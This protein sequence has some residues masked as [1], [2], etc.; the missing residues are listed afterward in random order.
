MPSGFVPVISEAHRGE[1]VS[2]LDPELL[3]R[4]PALVADGRKLGRKSTGEGTVA[5]DDLGL[6]VKSRPFTRRWTQH[7]VRREFEIGHELLQDGIPSTEPLAYLEPYERGAASYLV[8]RLLAGARSLKHVLE[9]E[10]AVNRSKL[11]AQL[12]GLVGRFHAAGWG[13]GDLTLKN[14]LLLQDH[15]LCLI[16]LDHVFRVPL[17]LRTVLRIHDLRRMRVSGRNVLTGREFADLVEAYGEERGLAPWL[18]RLQIPLTYVVPTKRRSR[19][20]LRVRAAAP[21]RSG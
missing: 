2:S 12:G 16:D 8:L 11:I 9:P 18:R 10:D 7:S 6:V 20:A 4:L 5:L 17:G 13:H 15:S 3:G 21:R 1:R 14:V 19:P